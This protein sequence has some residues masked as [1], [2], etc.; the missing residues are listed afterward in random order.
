L[1]QDSNFLLAIFVEKNAVENVQTAPD[2]DAQIPRESGIV[3]SSAWSGN[4][5]SDTPRF[6]LV[7][8]GR[9]GYRS[10]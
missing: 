8:P 10:E 5:H 3:D 2:T 6:L 1:N 4:H 7:R 9:S